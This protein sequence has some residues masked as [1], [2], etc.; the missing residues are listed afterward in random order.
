[1]ATMKRSA[2]LAVVLALLL[3]GS[4][5]GQNKFQKEVETEKVAV[6]LGRHMAE[7]EYEVITTAELKALL[8]KRP[9]LVLVD[10]MPLEASYKK[11]HI[12]GAVQFL[13]PKSTMETWDTGETAGKSE[14]D[15]EAML[16]TDKQKLVVVYCG[17]T[18]CGRSHNAA[19]W[20]RR[21]GYEN[22]KRYPGG[23]FAWKGA[24]LP[25][26]SAGK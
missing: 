21:K 5:C 23:L 15:Y 6:K 9:E 12:S 4:G 25:T 22:V 16:G 17:F 13:F 14:A 11:Q 3:V 8:D 10:A 18:A 7:G 19:L 2:V 24:G 1:M 20:A 26:V